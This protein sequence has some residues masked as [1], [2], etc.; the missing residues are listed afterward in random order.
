MRLLLLEDDR[1]LR[2]AYARRL[3][4]AGGDV[5]EVGTLAAVRRSLDG[6][7]FDCLVLD[8]LVPDGDA[9]RLV[10]DIDRQPGRPPVLMISALADEAARLDGL[11]AGAD[12]Y[13]AKPFA[14]D[15]LALRVH[16]LIDVAPSSSGVLRLGRVSVDRHHGTVT[17]DGAR[18]HLTPTQFR[19]LE[20]LGTNLGSAVTTDQLYDHCWDAHAAFPRSV[21]HPHMWRLRQILQGH[22]TIE[23][24]RGTG[25]TLRTGT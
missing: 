17:C 8:R 15:E 14:L 12:D 20:L 16:K 25:Y 19:L 13:M 24:R 5:V 11:T 4:R 9:L 7:G 22:L 18:I 10:E 21:V 23:S 3:R 2:A 1:R 6:A